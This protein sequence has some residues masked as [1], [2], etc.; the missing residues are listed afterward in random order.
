VEIS[1]VLGVSKQAAH[2]RF[3]VSWTSQPA[4][5]RYTERTRIV[6]EAAADVARGRNNGFIGTE[7]LLLAFFTQ[8]A[9]LAA[10][11][12]VA[13]GITEQ[14][15]SEEV[16]ALVPVGDETPAGKPPFT[17]RA[18]HTLQGAV[19]EALEL[20]HNY[21]GTE[22]LLLAFYRDSGGVAAKVLE[23]LGL[24]ADAARN[25]VVEALK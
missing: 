12:L 4:F 10:E 14:R 11:L 8:P 19:A 9:C 2:K 13:Q 1:S 16:G 20:G 21:I 17:P 22:H 25:G 24:D 7:H 6:V 23:K 18:Y 15:V 3:A 5:D